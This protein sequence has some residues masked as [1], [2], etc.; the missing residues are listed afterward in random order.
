MNFIERLI[1]RTLGIGII[2]AG[3][4]WTKFTATVNKGF[5]YLGIIIMLG[6]ISIL[7]IKLKPS[8]RE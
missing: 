2:L 1:I 5:S 6:G 3:Y 4:H 8:K 7:F